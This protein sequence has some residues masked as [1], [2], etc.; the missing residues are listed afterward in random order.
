MDKFETYN[1]ERIKGSLRQF[2]I[3]RTSRQFGFPVSL[4]LLRVE[5]R[6][7]EGF[8]FFQRFSD[9]IAEFSHTICCSSHRVVGCAH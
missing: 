8:Y 6:L 3:S 5:L 1:E 4:A 9:L 2:Y 7:R